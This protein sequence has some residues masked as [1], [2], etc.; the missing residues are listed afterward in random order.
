MIILP[1]A[2]ELL[3]VAR[4]VMWFEPPEQALREPVRFLAYLMTY[5]T[6]AEL[7]IVRGYVSEVGFREAIEN[8][9]PGILDDRSWAYWNIMFDRYPVPPM[10]RR[11]FGP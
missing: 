2:P 4:N 3:N 8:A 7:E 9:P 5:G 6:P 10:P 1:D 11:A